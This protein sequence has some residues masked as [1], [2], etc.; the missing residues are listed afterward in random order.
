MKSFDIKVDKFIY[1]NFCGGINFRDMF[2]LKTTD[3]QNGFTKKEETMKYFI[4]EKENT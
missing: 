2:K 4:Y 1:G 3:I